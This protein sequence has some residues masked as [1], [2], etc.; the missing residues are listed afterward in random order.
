MDGDLPTAEIDIPVID[1]DVVLA[2]VEGGS[3]LN[4][5]EARELTTHIQSVTDVMW[6]LLARAHSG[7]A[8]EALGYGSF[9]DYVRE[10]FNMSRSRA[11][12]LLDQAKVI[13][14]IQEAVPEG[15]HIQVS[16]AAARD[17]KSVI[18]EV[19]PEIQERTSGMGQ[20]EAGDMVE[21]ILAEA[22][23]RELDRRE[24][25]RAASYDEDD[26]GDGE[27]F[28]GGGGGGGYS[29]NGGGGGGGN[30]PGMNPGGRPPVPHVPYDDDESDVDND[31]PPAQ[32]PAVVRRLVQAAY[33]LYSSLSALQSM[34]DVDAVVG[35]I[36]Q[37]R[38][39]Q[40]SRSLEPAFAWLT[41]FKAAWETAV[42]S[43][44][45]NDDNDD[46]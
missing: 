31:L 14:A 22:R 18:G 11:Y 19:V 10:E 16:E 38:H 6:T 35:T 44:E 5:E 7:R 8:W 24:A 25:E 21:D 17:L 3:P 15:T 37:E 40:V 46:D 2:G 33:D 4:R 1:G 26:E 13:A 42:A 9:A 32:D 23:Q 36:P 34:P 30:F 28:Y 45:D 27:D 20:D 43:D 41:E 39:E 12:Q 29:G